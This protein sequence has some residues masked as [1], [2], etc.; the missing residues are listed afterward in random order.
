[1]DGVGDDFVIYA[2][3]IVGA[4]QSG[5][6]PGRVAVARGRIRAIESDASDNAGATFRFPNAICLPGLI[7][8]HAHPARHDSVFGIDPDRHMLPSGVTT[9]LSQGDV[10]ADGVRKYMRD[11]VAASRTRV[12]LA[13]NVSRIGESTSEPCCGNLDDV[14]VEACITAIESYPDDIWGVAINASRHACGRTDPRE[15]LKRALCVA[16]AT[17]RP[18]LYGM[19]P[20]ED[21]PFAEQMQCLRA[22]DVVTYCFRR[23]PHCIVSEGRVEPAILE[24][25][26]RGVLFDVGHGCA[27]FDFDVA[28]R[29]IGAGFVPDTI[30]TDLQR[31]HMA[32]EPRH[33]LTLTMSKLR[34]AGMDADAVLEATTTR[35][36]K[37][38]SIDGDTGVLRPGHT[39]DLA[40]LEWAADP[41]ALRDA[42]GQVR[43]AGRWF[44]R[45]TVRGGLRIAPE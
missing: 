44:P 22:G 9:V 18:L 39:A 3:R 19:R 40:I 41:V 35:A 33:D 42:S 23:Q 26:A 14:D 4:E 27:S 1:M 7:D 31:G 13:L 6:G 2:G 36:A 38:L 28:E 34:A 43:H 21:W 24:A 11:T 30:S 12:R 10:G 32:A 16:Q 29:A 15:V 37:I 5:A 8:I 17:D 25:R 45:L 20:A